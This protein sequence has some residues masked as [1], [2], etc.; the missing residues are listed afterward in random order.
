MSDWVQ[1]DLTLIRRYDTFGRV[2]ATFT[3]RHPSRLPETIFQP[4]SYGTCPY[5]LVK[6]FLPSSGGNRMDDSH[7]DGMQSQ[8]A[9]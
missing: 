9:T 5:L 2:K 1:T 6:V 8:R 4:I 3:S 7:G